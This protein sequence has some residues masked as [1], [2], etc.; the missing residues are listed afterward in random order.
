MDLDRTPRKQEQKQSFFSKLKDRLTSPVGSGSSREKE[1]FIE[2][3]ALLVDSG[4]D[5]VSSL[6]AVRFDTHSE[7]MQRVVDQVIA[8]V[9]TGSPLWRAFS[10]HK[11]LKN[12]MI[13][14]IRIGEESGKLT[15]NLEL[16]V[17]QIK[18][19][20]AFRSKLM[21]AM[22]YP[23]IIM[24]LSLVL[25]IG[26]F[27]FVIPRLAGVYTALNI[28]L[29][30]ITVFL[31]GMGTFLQTYGIIVIPL[32]FAVVAWIWWYL[33]I[34]T[35]SK[36]IGQRILFRIKPLRDVIVNIELARFGFLAGTMLDAGLP[37]LDVVR[38]LERSADFHHYKDFYS[39]LTV[40][41]EDGFSFADT[42]KTYP[43]VSRII[44]LPVQQILI[45]A[46][47]SGNL[48]R[49]LLQVGD[50]F[51]KKIDASSR[52]LSILLE[53]LMLIAVWIGVVFVALSVIL[54]VYNLVGGV[55]RAR[56]GGS[57]REVEATPVPTRPVFRILVVNEGIESVDIYDE[58]DGEIIESVSGEERFQFQG[59]RDGWYL[60]SNDDGSSRGWIQSDNVTEQEDS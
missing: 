37:I 55:S 21:S 28:E 27:V 5:I 38:S 15:E 10:R 44:P 58:P 1:D 17:Q 42:F 52:N 43:R 51:E 22:M 53:P 39:Y 47:R 34:R 7:Q 32:F 6:H 60:I 8:D 12:Y 14:F 40:Q 45:S 18:K 50:R 25:G 30:A 23:A 4:L 24:V 29:P 9:D 13:T 20:R 54:P 33:F 35:E 46:E 16:I 19:N 2:N 26:I 41:I 36:K 11:V 3:L 49:S 48:Q 59:Q 57:V 31:I 56:D